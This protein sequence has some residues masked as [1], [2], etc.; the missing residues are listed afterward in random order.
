M[1]SV[2]RLAILPLT[3]G[4]LVGAGACAAAA[5]GAAGAAGA[6]Y[7][8]Q[9]GAES[10]VNTSVEQTAEAVRRTFTEFHITETKARTE[11]ESGEST[12]VL[13]GTTPDREVKVTIA[14]EGDKSKVEVVARKSAVTWDKDLAKAILERVVSLAAAQSS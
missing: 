1:R 9:R 10:M 14:A 13:E 2:I 6:V 3:A 4:L 12:Q 5:A 7:Y 11:Q 8:N